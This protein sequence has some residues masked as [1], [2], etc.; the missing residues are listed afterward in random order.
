[1]S[2]RIAFDLDGVLADMESVLVRQA[3]VLFGPP[4]TRRFL[5]DPVDPAGPLS[6][7]WANGDGPG[8]HEDA[9]AARWR[10]ATGV[11]LDIAPPFEKTMTARQQQALWRHIKGVENFW[12]TLPEVEP[13]VVGRLARLAAERRWETIFLTTRPETAGSTAQDQSRQWL[14]SKGFPLPGVF[15][16]RGSRGRLATDLG[17]DIV[18]DDRPENCV[19]VVADSKAR[20]VLVWRG[21]DGVLPVAQRLG[22]GVVR[23]TAECLDTLAAMDR[24]VR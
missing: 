17:L 1:V 19:D 20:A 11:R 10:R 5:E 7:A 14:T 16:V 8:G 3:E 9:A 22:I 21:D 15:V 12:E 13:G 23:T 4:L 2:L 18:V 24:P 6:G